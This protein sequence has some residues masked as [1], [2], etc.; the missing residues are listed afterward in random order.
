MP[1]QTESAG[2]EPATRP[3]GLCSTFCPHD[4]VTPS[5]RNRTCNLLT[6]SSP[7]PFTHITLS[8]ALKHRRFQLLQRSNT[9]QSSNL[10]SSRSDCGFTSVCVSWQPVKATDTNA[11][12]PASSFQIMLE[13]RWSIRVKLDDLLTCLSDSDASFHQNVHLLKPEWTGFMFLCCSLC[14][15]IKQSLKTNEE[16]W[17]QLKAAAKLQMKI[18]KSES[19]TGNR[20]VNSTQVKPINQSDKDRK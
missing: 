15:H 14:W 7:R 12:D 18:Q 1:L 13:Q 3:Q 17:S 11:P 9:E 4:R 16:T 2:F 6:S 8:V 19:D 10:W 5:L 20:Q